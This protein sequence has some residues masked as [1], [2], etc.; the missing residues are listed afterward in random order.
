MSVG[1][2]SMSKDRG[3]EAWTEHVDEFD[4]VRSIATTLSE[5]QSASYI[6][7]E[8][9]VEE[10]ITREFLDRL[11]SVGVLIKSDGNGKAAYAPDP[12]HA[13]VNTLRDLLTEH[14]REELRQLAD[15]FETRIE[16]SDDTQTDRLTEYHLTLLREAI[17][18]YPRF[19]DQH[20]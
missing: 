13:R 17:D 19:A 6:A 5:P 8:A 18:I 3:V 12:L 11:E 15:E 4:R 20:R 7:D 2:A 16:A 14:D 10:D 1:L 9:C